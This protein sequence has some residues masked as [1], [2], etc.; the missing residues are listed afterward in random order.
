MIVVEASNV[1]HGFVAVTPK[2]SGKSLY[3]MTT[4]EI[5]DIGRE[6]I[7]STTTAG[8]VDS[9]FIEKERR[10]APKPTKGV[11]SE[12]KWWAGKE[13]PEMPDF[14]ETNP[15]Y[16]RIHEPLFTKKNN[17]TIEDFAI[18]KLKHR[19]YREAGD[20]QEDRDACL[21]WV[22]GSLGRANSQKELDAIVEQQT[23]KDAKVAIRQFYKETVSRV[24]AEVNL[25][26]HKNEIWLKYCPI[27]SFR[28]S[29]YRGRERARYEV[30]VTILDEDSP[31]VGKTILY[32]P[33]NDWVED[34]F[35]VEAL[36]IVQ[37]VAREGRLAYKIQDSSYS[38]EGFMPL[39]KA[40][41]YMHEGQQKQISKMRYIPPKQETNL[42]GETVWRKE[43]WR[44]LIQ[45]SRYETSEQVILDKEWVFENIDKH[46]CKFL[47]DVRNKEGHRGFVFIPEGDNEQ[48]AA[49]AVKYLENAP[50]VKYCNNGVAK[51]LRR[52][53][54]DSAASGLAYLGFDRLAI[55]I[56]S[57][58]ED[59]TTTANPMS[60]LGSILQE[61]TIK[62]GERQ[63]F[64]Y[65][66][67]NKKR[68]KHWN[69][70]ES[71]KEYMLC[72]LGIRSSDGKSDHAICIVN[73]E[74]IFDSNFRKALPMNMESL[75]LCSS[76]DER[77]TK[78]V[79]VT[80]GLLLRRRK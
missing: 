15:L 20:Y 24:Q 1:D 10:M 23:R 46:M 32:F 63:I 22:N 38:E 19:D 37:Q 65:L 28:E 9:S 11:E 74:W 35:T 4:E 33:T 36:T 51:A 48:H 2:H 26:L 13:P 56:G 71:P 6:R 78:F 67:L 66:S 25:A 73:G 64:E 17:T 77:E 60:L 40:L 44:G 62:E 12:D 18:G 54:L 30:L 42:L 72:V 68:V 34:N 50:S 55:L 21:R 59:P 29:K 39:G 57:T 31:D 69:A 70:L 8:N 14:G 7:R 47:K 27:P 52:C 16:A 76:S 61:K 75:D 53:V 3:D 43:A 41:K 58:R 79:E 5:I 45:T 80:R 49:E